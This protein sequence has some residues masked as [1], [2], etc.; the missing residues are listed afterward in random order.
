MKAESLRFRVPGSQTAR[1]F[2]PHPTGRP[3]LRNLL[4]EVIMTVE[5]K[6]YTRSEH[7]DIQSLFNCCLHIGLPVSKGEG[8]F[9]YRCR[10]CFTDMIA[11][12]RYRIPARQLLAAIFEHVCDQAHR[13]RWRIDIGAPR[14]IFLQ[15]I[16][17]NRSRNFP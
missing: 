4:E 13:G 12:Y 5:E 14:H 3:E 10:P 16:I 6:R 8:K 11:R 1:D 7:I 15:N 2:S 9:L 17:L